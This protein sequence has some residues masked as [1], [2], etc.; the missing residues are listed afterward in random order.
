MS[1]D[2][3]IPVEAVDTEDT[4][5]S[6]RLRAIFD[7]KATCADVRRRAENATSDDR[8]ATY[9]ANSHY[10]HAV[11][12]YAREAEPLFSRTEK[13]RRYW[14]HHDFGTVTI[15]PSTEHRTTAD[16]PRR[17]LAE[18]GQKLVGDPP[19]DHISMNG[20]N[21]LF[22]VGSPVTRQMECSVAGR[23]RGSGATLAVVTVEQQVPF[24]VVDD[25][26]AV[27]NGYL[28]ELG[29]DIEIEDD[30]ANDWEI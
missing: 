5:R 11:E 28:A 15:S 26:Y 24:S 4:V 29:L 6:Q 7:A 30:D 16:G 12:T 8:R 23:R 10:R 22:S 20:I 9:K 3:T 1:D 25:V 21:A 14:T 2:D 18:T 27:I 19:S 17:F 13:G